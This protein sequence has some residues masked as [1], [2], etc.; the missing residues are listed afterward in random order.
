M[1][2]IKSWKIPTPDQVNRALALL[3][4]PQQR[5]YFFN[6]LENPEWITELRKR[7]WF[8]HAPSTIQTGDNTVSFPNWAESRYLARMAV[9]RPE[10][11]LEIALAIETNNPSVHRDFIE[12]ALNM[13]PDVAARM[14]AKIKGW[15]NEKSP[16]SFYL[17]LSQ[18]VGELISFL[19]K[20]GQATVAL[21]LAQTLLAVRL[22]PQSKSSAATDYLPAPEVKPRFDEWHYNHILER[23]IPDLVAVAGEK[24]L[25]L[26][27]GLL[28]DTLAISRSSQN[29]PDTLIWEDYSYI[30]RPLVEDHARNSQS[31]DLKNYLVVA[32]RKAAQQI[33]EADSI[34]LP[35]I[36]TLLRKQHWRIFHRLMI[37]LVRRWPTVE[38]SLVTE[39]LTNREYFAFLAS[40][41]DY[42]Y[43]LLAQEQFVSLSETDQQIILS[44]IA[45]PNIV[46]SE[47]D[48]PD[49]YLRRVRRWKLRKLTPLKDHLVG[50]W[51]QTYEE[52]TRE[53]GEIELSSLLPS[54]VQVRSNIASPQTVEELAATEIGELVELLKTWQPSRDGFPRVEDPFD[55]PSCE[56][57]A[58]TLQRAVET[59]PLRYAAGGDQFKGVSARY[60]TCL[61]RGLRNALNQQQSIENITA[62]PWAPVLSLCLD[63]VELSEG[64]RTLETASQVL[65][66]EWREARRAVADTLE[67]GLSAQDRLTLPLKLRKQVWSVL[68]PLTRDPDPTLDYEAQHLNSSSQAANSLSINTVRGEAL[69][70]VIRYALWLRGY[71][72]TAESGT[73]VTF[74]GFDGMPEVRQTLEEHLNPIADP[75]LAIRSIYGQWFPWLVLLGEDWTCQ[76]VPEIFPHDEELRSFRQAAWN[77]YIVFCSPYNSSLRLL[78]EEYHFAIEQLDVAPQ[79]SSNY[80]DPSEALAQHLMTFYWQGHIGLEEDGL[81]VKFYAK[82]S[83]AICKEAITFIGRSLRNTKGEIDP[84]IQA[85][86]IAFW[87]FRL[88]AVQTAA[89]PD[90]SPS[91]LVAYGWWFA[92][93]KFEADWAIAQLRVVLKIVDEIE[94]DHFVVEQLAQLTETHLQSVL[95]CLQ[96]LVVQDTS[97]WRIYGWND[98]ARQILTL[99]L[100][101]GTSNIQRKAREIIDLLGRR[102]YWDFRSLLPTQSNP[103]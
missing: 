99:A 24:T 71:Q 30:W 98:E 56:G 52:L 50:Q 72:E 85:R 64:T 1:N 48:N 70:T 89:Q 63:I 13:P 23:N 53:L 3:V 61:L 95:E 26:L 29:Q 41:Q 74:S 45:H 18:K 33:L 60:L 79:N 101:Q 51:Q 34:R 75:S 6:R 84:D 88:G 93:G 31:H 22:T 91:E 39:I 20:G 16:Y 100:Q 67:L 37:T 14:E 35:A 103:Q 11:V 73:A 65:Y 47:D 82:A 59:D 94:A 77:S 12:A 25:M 15:I 7:K 76:H 38:P 57:L 42:E 92:S 81:L 17:L 69:H 36:V 10:E 87:N 83:T 28:Q 96:L 5:Q 44:W 32:I 55:K 90:D 27:C 54:G 68:Y 102:G 86:L 58:W 62:F 66:S 2:S 49:E 78:I 46:R 43:T 80:R 21:E 8:R 40:H 19:A 4:H 9:Y 97:D